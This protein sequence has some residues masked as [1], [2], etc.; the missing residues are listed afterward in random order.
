MTVDPSGPAES[1]VQGA[2]YGDLTGRLLGEPGPAAEGRARDWGLVLTARGIPHV[3]RRQ[4]LGWRLLVPQA[5][6]VEALAEI[7]AYLAERAARP[8]PDPQAMP[9]RPSVWP[10]VLAVVGLVTAVF[11]QLLGGAAP[12]GWR[13]PWRALGA[14]DSTAMLD[15]QW[16]RAVTSLTLHVDPAH[17]LGNAACGALFL[18]LLCRETGVGLGFALCLA[19][20]ILGNVEKALIQ[21]PGFHFLGAS[22]AVFGALGALG[23]VRLVSRLGAA[24]TGRSAP[25]GAVLMLLAMLGAGSEEGGAVDL[26]G[27]LFGFASG[28]GLGLAAGW[29][30]DRRG[31]PGPAWQTLCGL[32]ALVVPLLAWGL[33]LGAWPG[34]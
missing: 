30:V 2:G 7:E 15:G 10:R 25:I 9:E 16:W 31:W 27:H 24:L 28:V 14:G 5:R 6:M 23:G 12:F 11:G 32:W 33:A 4:G 13:I 17:L 1:A 29:L 8:L 19:A 34:P 22:T 21:G 3:L 20:G 26:A 18:C